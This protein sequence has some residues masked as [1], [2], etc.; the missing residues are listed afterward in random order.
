MQETVVVFG[1]SSGIGEAAAKRLLA[2]GLRVIIVGRDRIRLDGAAARLGHGVESATVDATDRA[3]LSRFYARIGSFQHLVLSF[4]GGK[5]A[6]P[7]KGLNM[8]DIRSGMERKFFAQFTA[9]D[10]HGHRGGWRRPSELIDSYSAQALA[11]S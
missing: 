3:A 5:G 7:F 8:D 10:R 6:V 9:R 4:S 2:D 11:R 1:G